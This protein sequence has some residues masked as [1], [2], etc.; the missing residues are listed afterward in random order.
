M[1]LR[2]PLAAL[3]ALLLTF[4]A[5]DSGT[6]TDEDGPLAEAFANLG[7]WTFVDV[8]GSTCRD[9]SDTGVGV[10][11]QEN[12]TNLMIYLEGGGACFNGA[13]CASNQDSYGK[14]Q[15]D[16]GD[17]P[18]LNRGIFQTDSANPVGDWNAVYVPYCTGDVHSGSAPNATV[19]GVA[20]TQQFVGHANVERALAL[21]EAGLGDDPDKVLLAGV[22]AGGFGTL[23][24]FPSVADA[25]SG[26]QAYLLNDSGPI[27][28]Q[29]NVFS[30]EL[31]GSFAALYNLPGTLP[32]AA[33]LYQPDG[34]QNIYAYLDR[35]YPDATFGL[36]SY[37]EDSTI[38]FF[39]GF[40]QPGDPDTNI[41]GA[42][43]ASGLRDIRTKV[44]D[45]W[46]T[47]FAS[48]SG[49]VFVTN[50]EFYQTTGGVSVASWLTDI[51]DDNPT[52]VAPDVSAAALAAR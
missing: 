23:L 36:A 48:G 25:F 32:E 10:R 24:N 17:A 26:S 50:S 38:R 47:Y 31:G 41:S 52:D 45:G 5:C 44:P 11:L 19:P 2:L 15:F 35:T 43:F 22:S 30:P 20:G 29:D 4:S 40:G 13:T 16:T 51:L 14:A 3:G 12:A 46:G 49:H 6:D 27:F 9:G 8:E 34:L 37:L 42:A 21:L 33:E 18:R 1:R 39:F 7:Q 28:F